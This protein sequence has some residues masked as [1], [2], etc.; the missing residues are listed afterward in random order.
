MLLEID[1]TLHAESLVDRE[2]YKR[3][4]KEAAPSTTRIKELSE[5]DFERLKILATT[6]Q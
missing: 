4:G 6:H 3:K 1:T 5:E 2:K